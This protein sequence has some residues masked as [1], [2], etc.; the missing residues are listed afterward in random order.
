[1]PNPDLDY[2]VNLEAYPINQLDSEAGQEL[3]KWA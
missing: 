1:M 3:L 2:F